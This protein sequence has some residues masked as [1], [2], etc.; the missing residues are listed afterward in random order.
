M[1]FDLLGDVNWLAVVIAAIVYFA[2][3]AAWY[4][5]ALFGK[6]WQ[7]AVGWDP[8]AEPPDMGPVG[9]LL[10]FPFF[11][12]MAAAVAMLAVA[13]GADT[14]G[15][16]ITLGVVIAI[17]LSLMHTAVDAA[18]EVSKPQPWTW[19]WINGSYHAVGLIVTAVILALWQ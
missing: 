10:P 6:A 11:V 8:E 12:V 7:A 3:G 18:F 5:P 19:F 9:Y 13:T 15:E 17:G 1:S 2:L 16:G 14:V 4:S